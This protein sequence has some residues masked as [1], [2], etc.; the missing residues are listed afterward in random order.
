MPGNSFR[1]SVPVEVRF[2]DLDSL[3]HVNNAVYL[4]YLEVGRIAYIAR[5]GL[6]DPV[7]PRLLVARIEVD[8]RRP[9]HLGEALT[10]AVRTAEVGRKSFTLAYEVLALSLIHI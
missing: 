10:V 7:R 6:T 4:T 5:L 9:V 3:G 1:F 8:Y 2:R